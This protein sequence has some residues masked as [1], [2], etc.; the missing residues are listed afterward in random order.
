[1]E[2]VLFRASLD[3]LT[4]KAMCT[5]VGE[6]DFI[7]FHS[8]LKLCNKWDTQNWTKGRS[9]SLLPNICITDRR[10]CHSWPPWLG[11]QL[12][13]SA[14]EY[15]CEKWPDIF[16]Q[17]ICIVH[18]RL[19]KHYNCSYR[20]LFVKQLYP[21][22]YYIPW[23]PCWNTN[24]NQCAQFLYKLVS[25]K[26]CMGLIPVPCSLVI[27]NTPHLKCWHSQE[28]VEEFSY[29]LNS[30]KKDRNVGCIEK[31]IISIQQASHLPLKSSIYWAGGV[32]KK[33][34]RR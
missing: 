28:A 11:I 1:M 2:S 30:I 22:N 12:L 29:R 8:F 16:I 24:R 7:V 14:F 5:E 34:F 18:C 33:T 6:I 32:Q 17:R 3:C 26:T 15:D 4:G 20:D 9:G 21:C 31:G 23:F 25:I 10:H 27:S 13:F 19:I